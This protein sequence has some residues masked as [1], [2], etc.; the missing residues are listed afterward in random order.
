MSK[1]K[2]DDHHWK[3]GDPVLVTF[4][5]TGKVPMKIEY[6]YKEN[7]FGDYY[8]SQGAFEKNNTEQLDFFVFAK[9]KPGVTAQQGR[10]A[11]SPLLA[12]YPNAKLQDNAQFKADQEAQ[13]DKFVALV[14]LLLFFALVIALIGI[15]NTLALSI[16]E[17][18]REIGLLRAVGMSRR[19]VRSAI[20]WESVIIALLG[21]VN[22]LAIGLFFGWSVVRA[23]RSQGITE[24]A[25]APAQLLVVVI[26]ITG[27]S[28]VA[29]WLPARRAAPRAV[30]RSGRCRSPRWPRESRPA[31]GRSTRANRARRA[32]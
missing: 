28:V 16:Y 23:L 31:S 12:A 13:V 3:L 7:T 21:A 19:Q 5:E 15:A 24:F 14:Y 6:I 11:I 8:V 9:L 29:A 20:R 22:G 27:L 32:G 4:V 26:I 10:A 25:F 2:A 17:R 18:T 1:K 30:P